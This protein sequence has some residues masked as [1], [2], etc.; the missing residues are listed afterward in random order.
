MPKT[1]MHPTEMRA[2]ATDLLREQTIS[3]QI[4]HARSQIDE[5][6]KTLDDAADTIL[7]EVEKIRA[8][9][10]TAAAGVEQVTDACRT[11]LEACLFHDLVSQRLTKVDAG[12]A[13]LTGDM[14]APRAA[15]EHSAP[16]VADPE[17]GLL[18]GPAL[19]DEG[20]DQ[21]DVDRLLNSD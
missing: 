18:N 4:A 2:Q 9:D 16:P 13:A 14:G 10:L 15:T 17:A 20:V 19:G 5:S 8:A 3:D 7:T 6:L 12:L 21:D 11:I 1:R